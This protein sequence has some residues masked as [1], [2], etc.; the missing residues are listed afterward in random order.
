MTWIFVNERTITHIYLNWDFRFDI[1]MNIIGEKIES[2][3]W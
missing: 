1:D 3:N 2:S